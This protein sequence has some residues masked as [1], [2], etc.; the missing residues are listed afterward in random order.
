MN[1]RH[2]LAV[3]GVLAGL[4]PVPALSRG[5]YDCGDEGRV[6]EGRTYAAPTDSTLLKGALWWAP[7]PGGSPPL[8]VGFQPP[9]SGETVAR[10]AYV[11]AQVRA[12]P[13]P[14]QPLWIVARMGQATVREVFFQPGHPR[15]DPRRVTEADLA[16]G[17][18]SPEGFY[19]TVR[20]EDPA[21]AEAFAAGAPLEVMLQAQDGAI[22]TRE[23]LAVAGREAAMAGL[24]KGWWRQVARIQR[25]EACP[26]QVI[27][28]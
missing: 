24:D 1:W 22:V 13:A 19:K 21:L 15:V 18:L 6:G 20:L 5:L 8:R 9:R 28:E 25:G 7:D 27:E 11:V 3:L 17:V 14:D 10:A 2:A 26:V 12:A 4:A 16:K 23:V